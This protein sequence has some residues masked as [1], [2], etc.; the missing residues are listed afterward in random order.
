MIVEGSLEF[1]DDAISFSSRRINRHQ[2]VI[3]KIYAISAEPAQF[4]DDL[5]GTDA[6]SGC[7]AK[8]IAT[9]IADRPQTE[10]EFVFRFWGVYVFS[11]HETLQANRTYLTYGSHRPISPI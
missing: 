9:A 1:G 5:H 6:G 4:F 2:I 8:W 7:F 11:H 10:R 3:V